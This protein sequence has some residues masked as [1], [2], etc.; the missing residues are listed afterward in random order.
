MPGIPVHSFTDIDPITLAAFAG[1]PK[2]FISKPSFKENQR[3]R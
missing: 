3:Q 2:G 1:G